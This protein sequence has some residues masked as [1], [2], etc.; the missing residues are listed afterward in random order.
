MILEGSIGYYCNERS[1]FSTQQLE[2]S[3]RKLYFLRSSVLFT[4]Q[5][6][7]PAVS[8]ARWTF[9]FPIGN[10]WII[11]R[12]TNVTSENLIAVHIIGECKL[13]VCTVSLLLPNDRKDSNS[14]VVFGH[15]G[16]IK[17]LA[18]CEGVKSTEFNR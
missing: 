9:F 14:F 10:D 16:I 1:E 17:R 7:P 8:A 5:W 2:I 4:G 13:L 18:D 11:P 6:V 12:R 3:A 15:V